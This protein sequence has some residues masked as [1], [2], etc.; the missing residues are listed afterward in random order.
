MKLLSPTE[1]V[2]YEV[3]HKKAGDV[4]PYTDLEKVICCKRDRRNLVM[5]IGKLRRKGLA[6]KNVSRI[7]Y[8]LKVRCSPV[9][10]VRITEDNS[11]FA[12]DVMDSIH[13]VFDRHE[14]IDFE[15]QVAIVGVAIG[16]ILHQLNDRDRRYLMRVMVKNMEH[17]PQ[18]STTMLQ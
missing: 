13:A 7:G 10:V 12:Q 8:M 14:N 9:T 2:L 3:L 6:I 1:R 5:F 4:V 11:L 16:S 17:A 15:D 18:F